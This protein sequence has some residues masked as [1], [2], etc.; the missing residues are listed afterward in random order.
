MDRWQK[1]RAL[2]WAIV[3][4]IGVLAFLAAG[5]FVIAMLS[6][7]D[8]GKST[9]QELVQKPAQIRSNAEKQ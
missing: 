4:C 8:I 7:A 6:I 3:E 5:V 2:A 9:Q 1:E